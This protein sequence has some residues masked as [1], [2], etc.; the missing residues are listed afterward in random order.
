MVTGK[1]FHEFL[2]DNLSHKVFSFCPVLEL[3]EADNGQSLIK[4]IKFTL[5]RKDS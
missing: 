2:R 1:A 4:L 3:A 5:F